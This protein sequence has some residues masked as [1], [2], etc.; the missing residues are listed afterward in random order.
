MWCR[1]D[2]AGLWGGCVGVEP[3][4]SGQPEAEGARG[5]GPPVSIASDLH[6][7]LVTP[8]FTVMP[9]QCQNYHAS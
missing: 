7:L 8:L 5:K 9:S 2:G 6:S 4:S 1:Q 3:G